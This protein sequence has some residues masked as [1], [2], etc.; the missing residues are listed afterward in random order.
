MNYENSRMMLNNLAINFYW[1]KIGHITN[2]KTNVK[3]A[4]VL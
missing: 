3:L 2:V 1:Q 4:Q